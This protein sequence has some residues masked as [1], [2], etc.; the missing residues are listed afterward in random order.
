M[1]S[2]FLSEACRH[3]CLSQEDI[4]K[5]PTISEEARVYLIPGKNQEGYWTVQHLLEQVE[6]K[7]IPIFKTLFPNC[8]AVFAFDNSSNHS[9]YHSDAL[10]A[11]RMNFRPD[12]KQNKMQS[13]IWGPNNQYQEIVFSDN[14][15]I[16]ELREKPKGIEQILR[17]RGL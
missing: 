17:E 3:L 15:H 9:A 10:L 12:E 14:Y 5:Y 8:V 7:A 11:N 16:L 6:Y 4:I 13:T 1:I 2:E